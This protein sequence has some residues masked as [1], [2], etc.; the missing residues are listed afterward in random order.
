MNM[1]LEMGAQNYDRGWIRN[2]LQRLGILERV[3]VPVGGD[4]FLLCGVRV[5]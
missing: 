4:R 1:F 5:V 2:E 3:V